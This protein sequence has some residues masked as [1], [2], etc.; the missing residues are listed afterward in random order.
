MSKSSLETE[1]PHASGRRAILRFATASVALGLGQRAWA[2]DGFPS[3]P[4]RIVVPYAAGGPLDSVTR[5]LGER[6]SKS[7]GQPVTIDNRTGAS[8]IIGVD[9]VAKAAPDGYTLLST[10]SD[11]QINNTVLFKQ[12][13]YDP[14]AD[15]TPIVRLGDAAIVL[16]VHRDSPYRSVADIVEAARRDPGKVSFGSIGAGSLN[17]VIFDQLARVSQV[18]LTHVPYRGEVLAVQDVIGGQVGMAL[19]SLLGTRQFIESG[20]LRP[21]ALSGEKRLAALP[22][23]RT[24]AE[25]GFGQPIFRRRQWVGIFVPSKTPAGIVQRLNAESR[26]VLE[27]P[28]AVE[29][30][31]QR[32]FEPAASSLEAFRDQFKADFE[33][34]TRLIKTMNLPL[35]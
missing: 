20:V 10:V 15:F 30:L 28:D 8:G 19:G 18:E 16:V 35:Q 9:A 22:D 1:A 32:G 2:Q 6:L 14:V 13:P 3:R 34:T 4:L 23:V 29:F 11:T 25:L 24:F 17:H 7:L 12:L 33:T 31:V 27:R 5:M 21:L 26:T